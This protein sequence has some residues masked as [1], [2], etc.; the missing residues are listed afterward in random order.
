MKRMLMLCMILLSTRAAWADGSLPVPWSEIKQLIRQ[1]LEAEMV[2]KKTVTPDPMVYSLETGAYRLALTPESGRGEMSVSGNVISGE[3][4]PIRIVDLPMVIESLLE[5]TGGNLVSDDEGI[6]FLPE[7]RGPFQLTLSF[8]LPVLEDV[9][10]LRVIL[11]V[12]PAI[13]N[14]LAVELPDGFSLTASPGIKGRDGTFHFAACETLE[15]RFGKRI[16]SA[17]AE[18]PE[19]E[20]LSVLRM[21]GKQLSLQTFLKSLAPEPRAVLLSIPEGFRYVSASLRRST[22]Q[23]QPDGMLRITLPGRAEPF[24]TIEFIRIQPPGE[25]TLRF[26]LP[27]IKNNRVGDGRFLIEQPDD[28]LLSLHGDL[29]VSRI[30]IHVLD[31]ELKEK[32]RG[33]PRVLR[34]EAGGMIGLDLRRYGVV[35]TPP[36]V[37]DALSFFVAF[38]ENGHILSVLRM[39]VPAGTGDR[40]SLKAPSGAD[41]WS[42]NVNGQKRQIYAGPDDHWMIPVDPKSASKIELVFHRQGDKLGLRGRLETI[43]P[44]TGLPCKR[45]R[46]GIAVPERVQILSVDGAV[47]PAAPTT[48]SLPGVF[49]GTPHFFSRAFYQGEGMRLSI[50]YKEPA[51]PLNR[52]EATR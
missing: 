3:I 52:S 36:V 31:P 44:E 11:P 38:E 5:I 51:D 32:F 50:A 26:H 16:Q 13:Q 39:N 14:T 20:L 34:I 22:V 37:L 12:A 25:K 1:N 30:P 46:V 49:I 21:R 18:S 48:D 42:L 47:S 45:V 9:R 10:S 15:V 33:H 2:E 8:V 6:A 23:R 4:K 19:V 7:G 29:P 43:L 28:G 41:I 27:Q 17:E 40:I 24:A 35:S